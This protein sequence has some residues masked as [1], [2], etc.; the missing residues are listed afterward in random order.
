MKFQFNLLKIHITILKSL[1]REETELLE[2]NQCLS[3]ETEY[4]EYLTYILNNFSLDVNM[5][6]DLYL[7]LNMKIFNFFLIDKDYSWKINDQGN[8]AEVPILNQEFS[9]D[10]I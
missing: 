10:L 9:V 1:E 3:D 4:K 8:I 5:R 2:S 7:E 6:E